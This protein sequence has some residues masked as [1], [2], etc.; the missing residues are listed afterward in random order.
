[1]L[2]YSPPKR[3]AAMDDKGADLQ[4]LNSSMISSGPSSWVGIGSRET[5]STLEQGRGHHDKWQPRRRSRGS[6]GSGRARRS[7][8]RRSSGGTSSTGSRLTS[9]NQRKPPVVVVSPPSVRMSPSG[10]LPPRLGPVGD[11]TTRGREQDNIDE[12]SCTWNSRMLLHS[13]KRRLPQQ[14][15]QP[16]M[17]DCGGRPS[18]GSSRDTGNNSGDSLSSAREYTT[19]SE[20]QAHSPLRAPGMVDDGVYVCETLPPNAFAVGD[21]ELPVVS[22]AG[23][24]DSSGGNK[25]SGVGRDQG[26]NGGGDSSSGESSTPE[27]C[28]GGAGD[29]RGGGGQGGGAGDDDDDKKRGPGDTVGR[30]GDTGLDIDKDEEGGDEDEEADK[31]SRQSGTGSFRR[32]DY[33]TDDKKIAGPSSASLPT[34]ATDFASGGGSFG[35][36]HRV[37]DSRGSAIQFGKFVSS[38]SDFVSNCSSTGRASTGRVLDG[39]DSGETNQVRRLSGFFRSPHSRHEP[40]PS[41]IDHSSAAHSSAGYPSAGRPVPD[42][43][44]LARIFGTAKSCA[45]DFGEGNGG[46]LLRRSGSSSCLESTPKQSSCGNFF[47]TL[48]SCESIDTAKDG[49]I[50]WIH[51]SGGSVA[52]DSNPQQQPVSSAGGTTSAGHFTGASPEPHLPP[53]ASPSLTSVNADEE[54]SGAVRVSPTNNQCVPFARN[55]DVELTGSTEGRGGTPIGEDGD[56]VIQQLSETKMQASGDAVA[57]AHDP[58]LGVG[59]PGS[60]G[61]RESEE[62]WLLDGTEVPAL[63][64]SVSVDVFVGKCHPLPPSSPAP[65]ALPPRTAAMSP[66]RPSKKL[67]AQDAPVVGNESAGVGGKTRGLIRSAETRQWAGLNE[68][69]SWRSEIDRIAAGAAGAEE[70]ERRRQAKINRDESWRL[71]VSGTSKGE[72]ESDARD[73]RRQSVS[74][75]RVEDGNVR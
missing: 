49:S 54:A 26:G 42:V 3:G 23:Q 70:A 52:F 50:V 75:T 35:K 1:M 31:F 45:S 32:Q 30:A 60:C 40:L 38:T 4:F 63:V 72:Q 8:T 47:E 44:M 48:Q 11:D 10:V 61:G 73:I 18:E 27:G 36:T 41:E 53:F 7:P 25:N 71:D 34:N 69:G 68:D 19:P 55:T 39:G 22:C 64:Q 46:M 37:F 15:E 59:Q 57:V 2:S 5:G 51:R 28:G 56:E 67:P 20:L 17:R 9:P 12:K 16:K 33:G 21:G 74:F 66:A 24:D 62:E 29:S 6:F 13:P 65:P 43:D 14:Q 58:K